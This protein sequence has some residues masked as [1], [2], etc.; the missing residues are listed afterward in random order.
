MARFARVV[1]FAFPLVLAGLPALAEDASKAGDKPE[2]LTKVTLDDIKTALQDAGYR[3]LVKSDST[4]EYV[5]S[6]SGGQNFFISLGG[7]D[8]Q[9]VCKTLLAETGGWTPKTPLTVDSLDAFDWD[10]AGWL[11]VVKY[12]DGK[13]YANYRTTLAGGITKAWLQSNLEAFA[14]STEN[15][16]AFMQK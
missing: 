1:A 14:T 10:N 4:G 15:F 11:T 5:S 9:K 12:K 3:A 8:D 2:V 6:G 7:C 13:Y 16:A